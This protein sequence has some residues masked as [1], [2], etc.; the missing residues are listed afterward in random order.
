MAA[1]HLLAGLHPDGGPHRNA[2][3]EIRAGQRD[4]RPGLELKCAARQRHLQRGRAFRVPHQ[5][6]SGA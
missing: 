2:G 1:T 3:F 5:Q 6:I 4:H